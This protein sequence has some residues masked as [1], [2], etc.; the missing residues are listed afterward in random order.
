MLKGMI[1]NFKLEILELIRDMVAESCTSHAEELSMRA[2]LPGTSPTQQLALDIA[3][4][5]SREI[6]VAIMKK[7]AAYPLDKLETLT[8]TDE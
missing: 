5:T 2:R 8:L 7:L 4:I 1:A 6:G 3:S